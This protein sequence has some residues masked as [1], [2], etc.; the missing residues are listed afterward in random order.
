MLSKNFLRK[1]LQEKRTKMPAA[2]K[3][4]KRARILR[5]LSQTPEFLDAEHVA[6]YYGTAGEVFTRSF[7]KRILSLKKVYFPRVNIQQKTLTF[8]KVKTLSD[9][10]RGAYGIMEPKTS[11]P[12]RSVS[13]MDLLIVPGVGFDSRGR[14]LGR[15]GGYYDKA[16]SKAPRVWK[17]GLCFREQLL[18]KI[19]VETHDIRVNQ[20][21]TD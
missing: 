2:R 1:Q 8:R 11:C 10:E 21:I 12:K 7:L 20:V 15:G 14:R 4:K 6:F 18:K 16:L 13:S 19:P 17:I 5:Q 3:N 9:F